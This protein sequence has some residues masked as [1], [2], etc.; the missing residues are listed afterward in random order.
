MTAQERLALGVDLGGTAVKVGVVTPEGE[1]IGRGHVATEAARGVD[2]VVANMRRAAQEAVSAAG[3]T[4]QDLAGVGL[5]APGICDAARGVVVTAVNLGWHSVPAARLLSD[6]L[7]LPAFLENDANCAALGEQWCGAAKGSDHVILVT[8]GTGVGGGLILGGKIY[9]GATGWAGEIGHM[10]AVKN[11]P[12][13]N[14]GR[15]GCLETVSSATAIAVAAQREMVAGRA[16]FLAKLAQEQQGHVDARL[17]I[18]AAQKG[19]QPAQ[20]ILR[21]AGEHLGMVL[22]GLVSAL[23][24]ELIVVGGGASRAGDFLLE[25]MRRVIHENAMPGPVAV[26]QVVTAQLGNDAGLIG[27]ASLVWR[28]G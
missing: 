9:P 27:A 14:C 19:D 6:A 28:Q 3:I 20:A 7:G 25:P 5:G 22:A 10:P 16:P 24:P 15:F 26:S 1:I 2:A 8:V 4:L 11:G 23:N 12:A 13:C 21:E 18:T 17:V